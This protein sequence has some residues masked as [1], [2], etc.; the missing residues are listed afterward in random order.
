MKLLEDKFKHAYA[1]GANAIAIQ[2]DYQ[3]IKRYILEYSDL[4][5]MGVCHEDECECGN[6]DSHLHE[7]ESIRN[8]VT[9]SDILGDT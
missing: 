6:T 1:S 9:P 8:E 7:A 2:V 5:H 3:K 4:R